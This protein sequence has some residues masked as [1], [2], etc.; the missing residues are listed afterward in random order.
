[1]TINRLLIAAVLAI[2]LDLL[3]C[4]AHA[5]DLPDGYVIAAESATIIDAVAPGTIHTRKE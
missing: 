3:L 5:V 2:L 1:M 4:P